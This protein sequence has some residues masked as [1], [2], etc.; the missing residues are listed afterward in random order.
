MI[1]YTSD[2]PQNPVFEESTGLFITNYNYESNPFLLN[3]RKRNHS[4]QATINYVLHVLHTNTY[5]SIENICGIIKKIN[6]TMCRDVNSEFFGVFPYDFFDKPEDYA[7]PSYASQPTFLVPL[8]EIYIEFREL[9]PKAITEEIGDTCIT[10]ALT[11]AYNQRTLDSHDIILEILSLICIGELFSLP[12][13]FNSGMS[14]LQTLVYFTLYND[15]FMEYNHPKK[16]LNSI[17]A[18]NYFIEYIKNRDCISSIREIEKI[19]LICFYTHFNPHLLQWTGPISVAMNSDFLFE[20]NLEQIQRITKQINFYNFKIPEEY[21]QYSPKSGNK[22]VQSLTSRGFSYPHWK[23]TLVASSYNTD[24]FSLGS[25]NHDDMWS[26]RRPCIAYFGTPAS[27]YCLRIRCLFNDHDFSSASIHT[28]QHKGALLG[29]INFSTNRGDI[30]IGADY[31]KKYNMKD[32]RIRFQIT[33]NTS[34]LSYTKSGNSLSVIYNNLSVS[35][36]IHHTVFD[37]Y[38]IKHQLTPLDDSIYYDIILY[39]GEETELELSQ[40]KNAILAFSLFMGNNKNYQLP[41]VTTYEKSEF[42]IS[43]CKT[44]DIALKLKTPFSPGPVEYINL[45]DRQYINDIRLETYTERTKTLLG[46]HRFIAKNNLSQ[47]TLIPAGTSEKTDGFSKKINSLD[48]LSLENIMPKLNKI[49]S[50]LGS[51]SLSI[52]QRYSVQILMKLFNSAKKYD[53]RFEGLIEKRYSQAYDKISYATKQTQLKKILLETASKLKSDYK[54]IQINTKK[55]NNIT[56]VLEIIH[57]EYKNPNL[58]LQE[59]SHRVGLSEAHLSREFHATIGQS[60]TSYLLK[61]RIEKAKELF[62]EEKNISDIANMCGYYTFRTFNDAFKRY[63]GTT[64]KKYLQ[65]FSNSQ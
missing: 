4:I 16:I 50:E 18:I 24:N 28:V 27:P 23:S 42:L 13:I 22:F 6:S 3:K 33:G 55:S 9:L 34:E 21:Y 15:S 17:E 61:I 35:Y 19:L 53:V 54:K 10:S 51:F 40:I 1:L 49:V 37:N 41:S 46:Q 56:K 20:E 62:S 64:A 29:H 44:N 39:S 48:K 26:R 36:Q 5:D 47:T 2:F 65:S 11:L 25:F 30:L 59:I 7:M 60:Y 57:S 8:L 12:E 45:S 14:K 38:K 52:S 32:L 43:E 58:S 63:T 31:K